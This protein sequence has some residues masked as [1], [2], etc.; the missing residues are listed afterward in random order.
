MTLTNNYQTILKYL[1]KNKFNHLADV[2]E[3]TYQ[4]NPYTKGSLEWIMWL[5]QCAINLPILYLASI[6]LYAYGKQ[7]G[8]QRYLFTTRDTCHWHRIFK[9]LFPETDVHY[10]RCSRNMF[11]LGSEHKNREYQEYVKFLANEKSVYVDIHGT[12]RHMIEYF[13]KNFSF[14]P[15]CFS[16]R[17][18]LK[19]MM[20]YPNPAVGCMIKINS[21]VLC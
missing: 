6:Y 9:R 15:P 12:G 14:I 13:S 10:F 16:Y 5:E 21:I 11:V 20:N 19:N 2:L 8:Y 1:R 17:V 3:K 4:H 7:K 18:A